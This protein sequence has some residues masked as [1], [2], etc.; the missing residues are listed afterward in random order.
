MVASDT[1]P[2][3]HVLPPCNTKRWTIRKKAEVVLAVQDNK[4]SLEDACKR[5]KLSLEEFLAW[6]RQFKRFGEKGLRT[7]RLQQYPREKD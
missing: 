3:N 6:Q 4:L 2:S 1:N 7:T 5:F